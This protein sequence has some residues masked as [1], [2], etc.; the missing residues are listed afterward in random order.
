MA[1][2]TAPAVGDNG[3]SASVQ[4]EKGVGY[5]DNLRLIEW[6][7]A[8]GYKVENEQET[9]VVISE[10]ETAAIPEEIAPIIEAK[11]E[12]E[13]AKKTAKNTSTIC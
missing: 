12:I 3:I 4:F 1:K 2:I 5:T 9:E 11:P 13:A 8:K 6:F 10:M 7:V